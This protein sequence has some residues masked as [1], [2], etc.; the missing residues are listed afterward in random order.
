[1]TEVTLISPSDRP[2]QPL[3]EAALMNEVRLLEAGMRQT[4]RRLRDFE[5]Q[6]SMATADFVRRYAADEL[7]ETLDTI[8]WLGEYRMAQ[9]IQEKLDTLKGIRFAH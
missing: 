6:F 9:T 3:I 7:E 8:E 5:A 2:L 4:Q 1:M